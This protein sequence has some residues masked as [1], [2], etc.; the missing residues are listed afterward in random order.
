MAAAVATTTTRV[1]GT[2]KALT[3]LGRTGP[4]FG[5]G[6][7]RPNAQGAS[8]VCAAARWFSE[9]TTLSHRPKQPLSAYLRFVV[10][11]QSMYKQ[12]NPEIKMTEVIK[13]IAQAWRE[14]PAAEKKV[15]EEAANEDWMA[16]KE[17][18]AKFKATSVPLQKV[19][20]KTHS[21]ELKSK[22]ERKKELRRLGRPKRPHSAYNIFVVERLQ[23]TAGN[24]LKDKIKILSE[25]W[26][27][28]PSSQK[29]AYIQ[30]AE[31]DKI[32]YENEMR[33]WESQ[34]VDV[35][36]ED[37]LRSKSRRRKTESE[38]QGGAQSGVGKEI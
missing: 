26:N 20:L 28:L 24:L 3:A 35:G 12:Q 37:L 10:Q 9:E 23:E 36:R 8:A 1:R 14:L 25:A 6:G 2:W 19:P 21:K 29:Q 33:S 13:K 5:R 4:F 31:D 22:S 30:L 27:N 15:Y 32:R 17:E 16:Y 18:L 7:E 11:R 34:M 38:N